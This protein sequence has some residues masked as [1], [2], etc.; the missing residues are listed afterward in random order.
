MFYSSGIYGFH[1]FVLTSVK[2]ASNKA[3]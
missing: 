3:M 2:Q 1:Y